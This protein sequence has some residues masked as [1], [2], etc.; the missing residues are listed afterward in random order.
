[1][2]EVE[3]TLS[4]S[5]KDFSKKSLIVVEMLSTVYSSRAH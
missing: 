2:D 1:M 4:T 3:R 5:T